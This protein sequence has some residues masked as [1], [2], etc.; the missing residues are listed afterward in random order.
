[1]YL[2]TSFGI[3]FFMFKS[4]RELKSIFSYSKSNFFQFMACISLKIQI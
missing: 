1:M 3:S 2:E 4:G